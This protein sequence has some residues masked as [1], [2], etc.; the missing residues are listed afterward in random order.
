MPETWHPY[1]LV[2]PWTRQSGTGNA[3]SRTRRCLRFTARTDTLTPVT[4]ELVLLSRVAYRDL[5][6][7]GSGPRGLLAVLAG[8]LRLGAS[9][10]QLVDALWPDE[11][12]EHPTKALQLLV[13]RT[14]ARLGADLIVSTPTGYRLSL[15][16]DQVDASAV[17]LSAA[18]GER[19]ARDGDHA[20][21]LRHAAAGL[22][23]CEGA[24]GWDLTDDDPLSALRAARVSAYR[25]LTRAHA[26]ALSRLGRSAEALEPLET[27]AGDRPR[28]EEV[29][30]ELLRSEAAAVGPATALA[31][32]DAYR[33][34]LRDELGSD[35]GRSPTPCS[36]GTR[37]SPRWPTCRG[38]RG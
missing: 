8:D 17:L 35:P 26:L 21:A 12:P 28:D 13:S 36:A 1:V 15:A 9:T 2:L 30:V 3:N 11:R 23:L 18:A 24:A 34:T 38:S 20:A 25:S 16:P 10:A 5:E 7:T 19:S 32:Y 27:L 4:I 37:T 31:R 14:R 22:A 33:R 29:L 6:I